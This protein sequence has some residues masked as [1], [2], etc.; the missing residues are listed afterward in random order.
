MKTLSEVINEQKKLV[1]DTMAKQKKAYADLELVK[2]DW[3]TVVAEL[4]MP[5]PVAKE[6]KAYLEN[7]SALELWH[8][9]AYKAK[10][11]S[12]FLEVKASLLPLPTDPLTD[13]V[14]AKY[15]PWFDASMDRRQKLADNYTIAIG[16]AKEKLLLLQL[17][18]K[19]VGTESAEI[20]GFKEYLESIL[21]EKKKSTKPAYSQAGMDYMAVLE[22][23]GMDAVKAGK[24][25]TNAGLTV[26]RDYK[27]VEKS[28]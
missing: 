25:I 19:A 7:D 8:T 24:D 13:E 14:I 27:L 1:D 11:K 23:F 18:E 4:P 17:M 2:L 6:L 22:H 12:A 28:C 20:D 10:K 26:G 9:E 16:R 3:D 15:K 5:E 21:S